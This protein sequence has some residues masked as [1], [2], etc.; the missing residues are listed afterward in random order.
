ME[1][2]LGRSIVVYLLGQP[3]RGTEQ[4]SPVRGTRL[5][6]LILG[7]KG[8]NAEAGYTPQ[9][10]SPVFVTISSEPEWLPVLE[11]QLA[12]RGTH[13][14]ETAAIHLVGEGYRDR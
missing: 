3:L 8:D 10:D 7:W 13:I 6:H 4:V 1:R 14:P 11:Y 5:W 9:L 12:E 2:V